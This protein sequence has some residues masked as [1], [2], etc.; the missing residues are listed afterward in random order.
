M[1]WAWWRIGID[2]S[3]GGCRQGVGCGF[4]ALKGKVL[5]SKYNH[6]FGKAPKFLGH[7]SRTHKASLTGSYFSH[8]NP[9]DTHW[10]RQRLSHLRHSDTL[11]TVGTAPSAATLNIQCLLIVTHNAML[12]HLNLFSAYLSTV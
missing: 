11:I 5:V 10:N 6:V 12:L 1:G 4:L 9:K 8:I 3:T 7:S 2:R